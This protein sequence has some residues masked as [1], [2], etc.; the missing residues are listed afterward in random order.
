M[1]SIINSKNSALKKIPAFTLFESVVAIS[2]ITVL[3]GLGT[4]IYVNLMNA[5]KPIAYYQAENEIDV[6]FQKLKEENTFLSAEFIYDNYRIQQQ[7]EFYKG[8]KSLYQITYTATAGKRQLVTENY[9]LP[10]E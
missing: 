9:L 2:I 3:I 1:A 10:N 8:N 4:T 5:E 6:L 7:I